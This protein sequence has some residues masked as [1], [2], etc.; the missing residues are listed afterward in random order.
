LAHEGAKES[1]LEVYK[2]GTINTKKEEDAIFK[3]YFFDDMLIKP[4]KY[5]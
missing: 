1:P 5:H 2:K 3:Y 4:D